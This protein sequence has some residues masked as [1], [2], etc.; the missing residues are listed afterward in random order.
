M[1]LLIVD[2]ALSHVVGEVH[3]RCVSDSCSPWYTSTETVS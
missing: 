2:E 3:F 1:V